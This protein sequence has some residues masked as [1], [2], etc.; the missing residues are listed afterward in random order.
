MQTAVF[1]GSFD[2]VTRG[3]ESIVKRALPLFD[4]IVVA[5]GV[6]RTKKCMFSPEQRQD[7]LEQIFANSP[8][9][10]VCTYEGL[11]VEFCRKVEASYLLRGLR[12]CAD[13]EYERDIAMMN[14]KLHTG[15]ETIFLPADPELMAI[16]SSIV[17]DILANGGDVSQF[18]PEG[19]TLP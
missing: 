9:V 19:I 16:K 13:L 18:L 14:R 4:R 8:Q 1:P 3:H 15:I 6:N 2:P 7:W 5:I 12:G 10:E 11:T 17:R